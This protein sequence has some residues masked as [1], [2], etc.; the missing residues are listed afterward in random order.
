MT[1]AIAG[2]VEGSA[3]SLLTSAARTAEVVGML[4]TWKGYCI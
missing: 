4:A 2:I 3:G 1:V